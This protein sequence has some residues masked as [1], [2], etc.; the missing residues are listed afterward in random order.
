MA[1][2]N[3]EP[4]SGDRTEDSWGKKEVVS[5]WNLR[6]FRIDWSDTSTIERH[7][8]GASKVMLLETS[9]VDSLLC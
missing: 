5:D 7:A 2:E 4:G 6:L 8:P 9:P 1:L 3:T